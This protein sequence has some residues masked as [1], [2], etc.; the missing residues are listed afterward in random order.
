MKSKILSLVLCTILAI[1]SLTGCTK[2]VMLNEQGQEIVLDAGEQA[3]ESATKTVLVLGSI[4]ASAPGI[5]K[6]ARDANKIS[7]EQYN[8]AVDLYNQALA[9]YSLLNKTLQVVITENVDPSSNSKYVTA[10]SQFLLDRKNLETL[11]T[12]FGLPVEGVK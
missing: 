12:A 4:F 11:I 3:Q 6:T 1:S 2:K 7:K 10:M 9:S 8:N 5:I